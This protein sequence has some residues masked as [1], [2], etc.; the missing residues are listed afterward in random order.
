[1]S[2]SSEVP[3][4]QVSE[5]GASEAAELASASVTTLPPRCAR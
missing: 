3:I 5:T 2:L 4:S 1:M